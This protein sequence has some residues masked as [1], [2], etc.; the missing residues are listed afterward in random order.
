[1]NKAV[2]GLGSNIDPQINIPA[3][4]HILAQKFKVLKESTFKQTK[5]I[6]PISQ[7]DF[8]NGA[9]LLET[10]LNEDQ[11]TGGLK[12]IEQSL[13]RKRTDFRFGPRTIDLD[14]VVWNGVVVDPDFYSRDFLRE[15]VLEILPS[16]VAKG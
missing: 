4:R 16:L 6:G 11:L 5:A 10:E 9:V 1:M 3:A 7:P 2:I 13:G 14:I 12:D 8:I 15:S